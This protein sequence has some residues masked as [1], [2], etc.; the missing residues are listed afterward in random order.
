MLTECT[1][2]EIRKIVTESDDAYTKLLWVGEGVEKTDWASANYV[3][4]P[5]VMRGA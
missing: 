3:S 2:I 1:P 4:I 5:D